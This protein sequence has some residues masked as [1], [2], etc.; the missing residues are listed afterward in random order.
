MQFNS[1]S[2]ACSSPYYIHKLYTL[3]NC[4]LP[5]ENCNRYALTI[6]V[7]V[8]F[9]RLRIAN[10]KKNENK[11]NS[12]WI[13]RFLPCVFIPSKMINEFR[14]DSY[15]SWA[16][17]NESNFTV[18]ILILPIPAIFGMCNGFKVYF[19][20]H[21]VKCVSV[22][23]HYVYVHSTIFRNGISTLLFSS[24]FHSLASKA[25]Q[26]LSLPN[27][28]NGKVKSTLEYY[29]KK[30]T[31]KWARTSIENQILDDDR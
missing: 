17:R 21:A 29:L 11:Q 30:K 6:L 9:I 5:I 28:I 14:L 12:K 19:T 18:F 23:D 26:H 8:G 15:H 22:A 4:Q 20:Y 24:L 10:R 7:T 25:S 1:F 31:S 27:T 13:I 2:F 16:L 3:I